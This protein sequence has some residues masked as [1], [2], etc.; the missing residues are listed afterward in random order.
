METKT[1]DTSA[2]INLKPPPIDRIKSFDE[3]EVP[4]KPVVVK[5]TVKAPENVKLYSVAD[6][7]IATGSF[8]V[9]HLLG[10]GSFG[11]VYHAQFD[12]RG[13]LAVK[14]IYSSVIPNELSENFTEV[15]SNISQL[16]HPNVTEL[17]GYC[18]EHGQHLLV[19]EFLKN[20]SLHDFLHLSDEYS[21]PL[22]WNSRVKIA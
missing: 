19:Y 4:K 13:V 5:K 3:D 20:G 9:D 15:V 7:Q 10:E 1:F 6:L 8:S 12:D 18:S 21:K 17:I 14:K 16:H 11:R 22:I 2:S